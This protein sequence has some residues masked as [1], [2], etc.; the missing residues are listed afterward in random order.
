MSQYLLLR[1]I[2]DEQANALR[3]GEISTDD[4]VNPGEPIRDRYEGL[5]VVGCTIAILATFLVGPFLGDRFG[6]PAFL[7]SAA[8][9]LILTMILA[10]VQERLAS[11]PTRT[12]S[13]EPIDPLLVV[14]EEREF[15]SEF[16]DGLHF[17]LSGKTLKQS[18]DN[19]DQPPRPVEFL[20][21]A[22]E[23]LPG[24]HL[25]ECESIVTPAEI[26]LIHSALQTLPS[27]DLENHFASLGPEVPGAD[28]SHPSNRDRL[29]D[30]LVGL[31]QFIDRTATDGRSLLTSIG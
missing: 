28:W 23:D 17:V 5:I 10:A 30:D 14:P 4:L 13:D 9:G 2:T 26:A 6:W 7:A 1:A 15:R 3:E 18:V 31:L 24:G 27:A 19:R 11:R 22:G 16:W 21:R 20:L 29:R 12:P 25:E 8:A